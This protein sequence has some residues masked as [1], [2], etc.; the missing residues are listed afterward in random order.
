M[1]RTKVSDKVWE[2][3]EGV[4]CVVCPDCVFTFDAVHENDE[5]EGTYSCPLCETIALREALRNI[6]ALSVLQPG[7]LPALI[8]ERDALR[9]AAL[10]V[11]IN[12]QQGAYPDPYGSQGPAIVV[13]ADAYFGLVAALG[14][15]S[16]AEARAALE[17]LP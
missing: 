17:H 4:T 9:E 14:E 10:Q 6:E 8:A 13:G 1:P 11:R 7:H 16:Q 15:I 2:V 5:P 3:E 12:S